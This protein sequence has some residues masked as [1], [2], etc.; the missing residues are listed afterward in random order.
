M[1]SQKF[2]NLILNVI[3]NKTFDSI[4]ELYDFVMES[5]QIT[6]F[7]LRSEIK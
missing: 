1:P 6:D 2:I 4:C 7:V 3:D 5:F